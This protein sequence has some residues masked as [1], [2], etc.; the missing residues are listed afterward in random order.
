M[1]VGSIPIPL[2]KRLTGLTVIATALCPETQDRVRRMGADH[3][4]DHR[5]AVARSVAGPPFY[6]SAQ[7]ATD[8]H[9][10][11]TVALIAPRG[12]IALIDDSEGL[13]I[14]PTKPKA[15][16]LSWEF[17]FIRSI[18][19]TDM[20][21]QRDLLNRVSAMLDAQKLISTV[22]HRAPALTVDR[23]IV[24]HKRKESGRVIG[25]QVLPGL[26]S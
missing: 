10:P 9:L 20:K 1:G 21:A 12:H 23:L 5:G 24:A 25:K 13:D 7:N 6:V 19:G 15:L 3:V 18:L 22:N 26:S 14:G 4:I 17:M 11:A 2:A 8:Q 16:T